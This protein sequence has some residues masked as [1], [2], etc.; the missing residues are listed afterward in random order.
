MSIRKTHI[1]SA[2]AKCWPYIASLS[3]QFLK[4]HAARLQWRDEGR[5]APLRVI[6][7]QDFHALYSI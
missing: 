3:A 2:A 5:A 7:G 4:Q 1:Y 6:H